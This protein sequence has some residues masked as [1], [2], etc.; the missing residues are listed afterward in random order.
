MPFIQETQV[1]A[2]PLGNE[3]TETS[4]AGAIADFVDGFLSYQTKAA[5]ILRAGETD[6]C[7]A[8]VYAAMLWMFLE[9]P[10][11]PARAAPYLHRAEAAAARANPRERMNA[12]FVR[13][14]A[15]DDIPR[16]LAIGE[17]INAAYPRDLVILKLRQ[18]FLFNSGD[19]AGM[20]RAALALRG[21]ND[22]IAPFHGM[23]AF[24]YEECHL[25]DE[26]EDSARRALAMTANEPWAQHAL[27]HVM[28]TQARIDEGASF[29]EGARPTWDGLNSFMV[30][31]QNWHLALF[32]LSQG[33]F[34]AALRLYDDAV[35]GV[36]PSYSQDQVG[37]VS[38]LARLEL[39]G[40]DVGA[41]W[42]DLAP[43]L[44]AR[45]HDAV[46]PFLTLQ[47]LYGL[48]RAGRPEANQLIRAAKARA[49]SAPDYARGVWR[50]VAAPAM[51][52][53]AAHAAGRFDEAADKLG[54]ALPRLSEIG[55][56]HAQRDL[57]EQIWLDALISA[58]RYGAAQQALEV[59]RK[60]DP[61]GVP[62]NAA[63]GR[64]YRQL[65]LDEESAKAAAR[66]AETAA[67][68]R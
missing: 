43:H 54:A 26:A 53:L 30:T 6:S 59:R 18:Y 39:A 15:E 17:E 1:S 2:D 20:L 7:L 21:A 64:V 40:V 4:A 61:H 8:N 52:G 57:F 47:Y 37:A 41:R 58:K 38:L 56:S 5:N 60:M 3:V 9:S 50:D 31:H 28:L 42:D 67:R 45:A 32:Y 13:A 51:E 35:W 24:G 12:A 68:F 63:L 33:R 29:L 11:A 49:E 19:F 65:G 46:L 48:A 62:V 44:A 55:G 34:E 27:A 23:I 22:D 66:A 25:L 16:A 14:W 10:E 36:D